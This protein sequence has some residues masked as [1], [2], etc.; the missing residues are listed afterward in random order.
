ML[1]TCSDLDTSKFLGYWLPKNRQQY[2]PEILR[3]IE[4]SI[5]EAFVKKLRF[6]LEKMFEFDY[7]NLNF[8]V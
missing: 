7:D 6:C 5:R 4:H 2:H 8:I 3:Q 1:K